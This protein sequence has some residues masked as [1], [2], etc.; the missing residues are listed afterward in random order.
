MNVVNDSINRYCLPSSASYLLQTLHFTVH[1]GSTISKIFPICAGIPQGEVAA[2]LLFNLFT[3]NQPTT[4]HTTTGN[5]A[6]DQYNVHQVADID[7]LF[8]HQRH[9]ITLQHKLVR[10]RHYIIKILNKSTEINARPQSIDY[11]EIV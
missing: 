10:S 1:S 2:Q 5:F 3:T 6:D 11:T 8:I 4:T 9:R 7:N